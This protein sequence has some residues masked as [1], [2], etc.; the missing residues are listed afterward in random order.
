MPPTCGITPHHILVAML[1]LPSW[2][3]CS[4]VATRGRNALRLNHNRVNL[5]AIHLYTTQ[6]VRRAFEMRPHRLRRQAAPQSS[7]KF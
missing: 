1:L 2:L 4:R 5:A 6:I 3:R 7:L